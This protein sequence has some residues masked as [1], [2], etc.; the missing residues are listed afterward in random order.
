MV[1]R[2]DEQRDKQRD[3]QHGEERFCS[4]EELDVFFAF[5]GER[6]GHCRHN[7]ERFFLFH[8]LSN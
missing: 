2:C 8:F 4:F 1:S 6:Q 3:E 7:V 5:N